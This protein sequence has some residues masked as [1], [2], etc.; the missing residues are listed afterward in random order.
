MP[1]D[2]AGIEQQAPKVPGSDVR[3]GT[4]QPANISSKNAAMPV[5]IAKR[6][7]DTKGSGPNVYARII[8]MQPAIAIPYRRNM[9]SQ[10]LSGRFAVSE[11]DGI[12]VFNEMRTSDAGCIR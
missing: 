7:T 9:E 11:D 8:R 6:D 2:G 4:P 5:S 1:G 12:Q 10:N 3:N